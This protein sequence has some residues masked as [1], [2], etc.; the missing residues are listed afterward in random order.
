MLKVEFSIEEKLNKAILGRLIY[1]THI[2][3][4]QAK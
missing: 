1:Q 4:G 3:F 2:F